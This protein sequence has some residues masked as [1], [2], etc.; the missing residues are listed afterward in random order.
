MD[1]PRPR[2]FRLTVERPDGSRRSRLVK[3]P[4]Y[5]RDPRDS[6]FGLTAA[7]NELVLAGQV[8]G[9]TIKPPAILGPLQRKHLARWPEVLPT[10]IEEV[11]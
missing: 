2:I 8:A 11:A 6:L 9:Y 1:T 4:Y 5:E 10:L 7:L 3:A